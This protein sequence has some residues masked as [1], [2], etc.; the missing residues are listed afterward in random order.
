[1]TAGDVGSKME[2]V[3]LQ[4]GFNLASSLCPIHSN[5]YIDASDDNEAYCVYGHQHWRDAHW[6]AQN[7]AL[8]RHLPEVIPSARYNAYFYGLI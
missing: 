3:W 7:G 1:M 2:C 4:F 6:E 5:V 8:Q